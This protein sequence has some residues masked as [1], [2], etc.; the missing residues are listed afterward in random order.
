MLRKNLSKLHLV[1]KYSFRK[2]DLIELLMILLATSAFI[3][4]V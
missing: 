2:E 3:F 1:D 4:I